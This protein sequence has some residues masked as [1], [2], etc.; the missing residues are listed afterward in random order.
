M[1]SA[2]IPHSSS[3]EPVRER[4]HGLEVEDPFRWLEDQDS[5]A[6]RSFV[7]KEQRIFR[8]YLGRHLELRD[9]IER[10][11]KELLTVDAVDLPLSDRRGGL[12]YLKREAT[13]EQK[14]I[15]HHDEA[16]GEKLL[17]SVETLARD[18]FTSLAIIHIS[19]D[20]RFLAFGMR[21]G[22]EDLQEIGVYDLVERQ[23][24]PDRL[25]RGFHRGLVFE[26]GG[27]GFYYVH[28]EADGRYQNRRAVRRHGFSEEQCNDT[29][30]FCVGNDPS[31]RLVVQ[32][33]EDDSALGYLIVSLQSVPQARF[34]VH[35]FPLIDPPQ[36]VM[37]WSEANLGLRFWADTIETSTTHAAALGRVVRF[38]MDQPESKGW[39]TIIPEMG[40]SIFSWEHLGR[41]KV[42]HYAAGGRK[43]TR[44]YSESGGL[45]RTIDYPESGTTTFGQ[46]D[47]CTHRYFYSH[48]DAT[49]PTTI[50]SVDLA[51]GEHGVWW[52]QPNWVQ[53]R[54]LEVENRTYRSEDGTDIPITLIH[55]RGTSGTRPVLL[56]AYGGGGVSITTKFSV[57]MTILAEA[58]FTCATAHVRGGGE[59][60]PE[61]HLAA[62]RQ[63]KQTAVDDLI[64][65]AQWLVNSGYTTHQQLGVAGQS[66]GALLA[67]CAFI[68]RPHLFRAVLALGPIAD[69]TRFHLFGVARGFV[70]E[71]GSP[72]DP[73]EFASL[74][75]LSP[76]HRIRSEES[77]PALLIISGDR[78][79]R[80]DSLHARKMIAR[81]REASVEAHPI[82][83]DYVEARGHKPVLPLTERIR[84]LA[85]RLTFLIAELKLSSSEAQLS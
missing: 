43:L 46:L 5:L 63:R 7:Q 24:L 80:C 47:H 62:Q 14:A 10:R 8:D 44:I 4:L 84:A 33:S 52:R 48:C 59:R 56:S 71:L 38:S 6:T 85:D 69:L 29:E 39:T 35:R 19:P 32:A 66:S 36:E 74:L 67:L 50:Y 57:L 79:K 15:Y 3:A 12:V 41:S 37:S 13:A 55:P 9:G 1:T 82:L 81:L 76:Y 60:G 17:I 20:G 65:G 49:E 72:E 23:L 77:Y 26:R 40:E 54:A 42:I 31:I 68:E 28:E 83:L 78:D 51:T 18:S 70:A 21:S 2:S 34:L 22:G 75:R 30:I 27:K 58:G 45:V 16:N 53:R 11:V 73:D 64:S 25:P 61:W